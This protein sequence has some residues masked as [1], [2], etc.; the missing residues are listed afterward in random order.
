[1]TRTQFALAVRADAKWV[2]NAARLL[3]RRLSYTVEEA[4]WLGLVRLLNHEFGV[5]LARAAGLAG[6]V[7]RLPADSGSVPILEAPG[8][9]AA[10]VV[11]LARYHS[12]FVATLSAALQHGGPRRRGRKR[13]ENAPRDPLAE[14][15]AYGV[16][17][18]LFQYTLER[19]VAERLDEL[20]G[21][22]E[23]LADVRVVGALREPIESESAPRRPARFGP[24]L[25]ALRAA[26]I[27]FVVVGGVA[28]VAH[29]QAR[30][31]FDLDICYDPASGNAARLAALLADW[32]AYPRGVAHRLPF[33]MDAR[34][35]RVTPVLTLLTKEGAIDVL[36]RV[37]GVGGY[38]ESLARSV[39]VEA[40]GVP[41]RTL[42]LP[43]LV[44]AKRAA[45]RTKDRESLLELEAL[46]AIREGVSAS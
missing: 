42:D 24:M 32:G 43:A 27:D 5:P 11:D 18:T 16:D 31:T 39:E 45:G 9:E 20:A 33:F 37:A 23:F 13:G 29:G 12:T 10:L 6:S 4:R 8:G 22:A 28:G 21:S 34:Q 7:L 30:V 2:E 46:L 38:A 17:L 40:F 36:D 15:A 3:G 14:A 41:F 1:M 19:T 26:A 25:H 44:A 35:L